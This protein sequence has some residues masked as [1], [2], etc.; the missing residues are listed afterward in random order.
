M[1]PLFIITFAFSI[2]TALFTPAQKA[3]RGQLKDFTFP[4]IGDGD[5]LIFAAGTV[6]ITAPGLVWYGDFSSKALH[7]ATNPLGGLISFLAP[8]PTVGYR[9][10]LGW[11]LVICIGPNVRLKKLWFGTI[12]DHDEAKVEEND[13]NFT[14]PNDPKVPTPI[15]K[16]D[17]GT[18]HMQLTDFKAF[19]GDVGPHGGGQQGGGG[20]DLSV[21]FYGGEQSQ[22]VN[23]Y[24]E[25]KIDG[26]IPAWRGV[27]HVVVHGY[28]GDSTTLQNMTMEVTRIYDVLELGDKATVGTEGDANPANVIY[29]LMTNNFGAASMPISKIK[30]QS[31]IDCG[32][33]LFDEDEGIS[34]TFGGSGS[35]D[36]VGKVIQ[37][38]LRQIDAVLYEDPLDGLVYMAL[39]RQDYTLADLPVINVENIADLQNFALNLWSDT[40]NRVRVTYEDRKK[41]YNDRVAVGEDMANVAF[42][43]GQVKGVNIQHPYVKRKEHA[44]RLVARE[45]SVYSTILTKVTAATQRFNLALRPGS[46]IKFTYL[47]YGINQVIMRVLKV[48]FG[49]LTNNRMVLDLAADK[50][51]VVDLLF[52]PPS[53]DFVRPNTGATDIRSWKITESP[54]WLNSVQYDVVNAD[55]PRALVLPFPSNQAQQGY[56]LWLKTSTESD[57]QQTNLQNQYPEI[58]TIQGAIAMEYSTTSI[59]FTDISNVDVLANVSAAQISQY[60][61][62]LILVDDEFMAFETYALV[63]G[64]YVVS[65]VHRGLLDSVVAAHSAGAKAI[66]VRGYHVGSREFADGDTVDIKM[67]SFSTSGEQTVDEA[68]SATL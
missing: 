62:N 22:G 9:Y 23:T 6:K 66:F 48:N 16:G 51:S 7:P 65:T 37:D 25:A 34:I 12:S 14:N 58:A 63:G 33:K 38:I 30:T 36:K 46:V 18:T 53:T 4:Q 45:M 27:S 57:Y 43:N 52:A 41:D 44:N 49:S 20:Y 68:A 59:T 64:N 2:L 5:P 29:E 60:A 19:G 50:F 21:D 47:P 15:F 24:L 11:Q 67:G 40:K 42:Q 1:F 13:P 28:I 31:F 8:K 3:T 35:A 17:V 32:N 39:I 55:A 54:R 26:L 56:N 61:Y 10:Y